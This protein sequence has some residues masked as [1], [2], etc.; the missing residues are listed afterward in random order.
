M[1][2]HTPHGHEHGDRPNH[3]HGHQHG[4]RHDRGPKAVLRY[5]RYAPSMWRSEINDAVVELAAPQPGEHVVDVGAGVLAGTVLAAR[6][7]AHV[8]AV[9]PTP[10]MRF[11][12]RVRRLGQRA[13]K[14]ITV[15]DG[16]A[17]HL[18]VAD[19]SADAIWAVNSMHHWTDPD[20]AAVEIVRALKPGGRIVLVDED[21]DDPSHP[22]HEE[23]SG[24]G[25][26][27]D[28]GFHTVDAEAMAA[29][30]AGAGLVE[31]DTSR[32]ELGGRPVISVC[33]SAPPHR[34]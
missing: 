17:E 18:P 6:R 33:G 23:F 21:F 24:H 28:H 5:L 34:K 13:R 7:G 19:A 1:D 26:H 32:T 16:A 2:E 29:R 9:E 15:A 8:T 30:L 20:A 11:V 14:L 25:S 10:Y 22:D 27:E 31:P 3:R 12:A 4:H